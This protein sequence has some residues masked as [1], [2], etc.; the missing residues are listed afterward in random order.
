[1]KQLQKTPVLS[2]LIFI[3]ILVFQ[4]IVFSQ[5]NALDLARQKSQAAKQAYANL[6][7]HPSQPLWSEALAHLDNAI[8]F[9]PNNLE[10][11]RF[12]AISYN[13]VGWHS[14]TWQYGQNY[15][16]NGGF[17]DDEVK[18]AMIN[19]GNS[20]GYLF[21]ESQNLP[22]ALQYYETV[23]ALDPFNPIALR[24]IGRIQSE[25]GN[26]QESLNA[27]Q[28]LQQLN[29]DDASISY[30][31]NLLEQQLEWGKE[32]GTLYMQGLSFYELGNLAE[33]NQSFVQASDINSDYFDAIKWAARTYQELGSTNQALKYWQKAQMIAPDN[34]DIRYFIQVLTDESTSPSN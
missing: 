34:E 14:R 3:I 9:S 17:L 28:V 18:A 24:W 20:L 19:S 33:A 10:V 15:I 23:S 4:P 6:T 13:D 7:F 2:F 1:M 5:N 21:Y 22:V 25:A 31:V 8:Q 16:Q 11:L 32:A 27:W 26:L 12:A 30:F 29:P